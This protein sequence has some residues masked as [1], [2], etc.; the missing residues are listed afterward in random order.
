MEA[1]AE[2]YIRNYL[3]VKRFPRRSL[4][5]KLVPVQYREY[6]Y[7]LFHFTEIL[8]LFSPLLLQRLFFSLVALFSKLRGRYRKVLAWKSGVRLQV[9]EELFYYVGEQVCSAR[10]VVLLWEGYGC[11]K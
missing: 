10:A 5:C 1:H 11:G 7:G 4:V 3:H 8:S 2:E 6:E 9:V